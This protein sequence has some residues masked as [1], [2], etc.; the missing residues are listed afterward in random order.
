MIE[1]TLH[2]KSSLDI[3]DNEDFLTSTIFGF[4]QYFSPTE[5]WNEI[6]KHSL[7]LHNESI[8]DNMESQGLKS[9]RNYKVKLY[10]WEYFDKYGE[11][12][13]ILELHSIAEKKKFFIIIEIKLWSYKSNNS[14]E[15][16]LI[17]Y[18]DLLKDN[19]FKEK[20]FSNSVEN[21]NIGLI[22]LTPRNSKREIKESIKSSKNKNEDSKNLYGIRWQKIYD[23]LINFESDIDIY[24]KLG[25]FIEKIGLTP[26]YGFNS[27]FNIDAKIYNNYKGYTGGISFS[28]FK[29]NSLVSFDNII[30]FYKSEGVH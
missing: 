22:Y 6:F 4:V 7:N 30:E 15:D 8:K 5:L 24:E 20:M 19:K 1:S 13:I 16:Q 29:K 14:E 9:L 27:E 10:F 25:K 2:G 3:F 21:I 11:P 26:F 23:T 18:I 12:D 17:R 28:G